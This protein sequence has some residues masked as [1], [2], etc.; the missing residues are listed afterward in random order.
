MP[1]TCREAAGN[2]YFN[3]G[4][5][6]F[7]EDLRGFMRERRKFWLAPI[8][9]VM[10]LLATLIVL[11]QGSSRGKCYDRPEFKIVGLECFSGAAVFGRVCIERPGGRG[12]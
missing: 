11:A 9:I 6:E 5:L 8:I 7:F 10:V 2:I 4:M 1:Q 3:V 12:I